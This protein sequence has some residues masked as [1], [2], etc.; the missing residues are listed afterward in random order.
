MRIFAKIP[1]F[2]LPLT[3]SDIFKVIKLSAYGSEPDVVINGLEE[4]LKHY[5]GCKKTFVVPSARLGLKLILK[6]LNIEPYDEVIVPSWTYFAV[7]SI[8]AYCKI[9]PVFVDIDPDTCNM[10]VSAIENSIT[11]KTKAIIATHLYG[12][13][14]DMEAVIKIADKHGLKIIEDCAQSFGA[15][16][17]LKKTGSFGSAAFYSFGMTKNF[18]TIDGGLVAVNDDD[19][20]EIVEEEVKTF[21]PKKRLE[22]LIKTIK[23]L[24]MKFGTSPIVFSTAVYP[25]LRLFSLLN[26]DIINLLFDEVPYRIMSI[27]ESYLKSN[28]NAVQA[29]LG[30][31]QLE[32]IDNSNNLRHSNGMKLSF[33]LK[34]Q[35]NIKIVKNPEKSHNI[36][37]SFPIQHKDRSRMIK[38]LLGKGIDSTNGFIRDCSSHPVFKENYSECPNSV[39]LEKEIIHIPVYPSLSD[40]E[41]QY[42]A[43]AIKEFIS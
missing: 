16:Y 38:F 6:G 21:S 30:K 33:L 34:D 2:Q 19:C 9:K 26:K 25:I 39:R 5:I 29:A 15:T 18:S 40:E 13:P 31:T 4:E 17:D 23:G 22:L 10:D 12:L 27:P 37:L 20:A 7:P 3:F 28:I 36:Y 24:V 35:N 14:M 32:I 42:I 1:R 43:N 41:M 11:K 8:L